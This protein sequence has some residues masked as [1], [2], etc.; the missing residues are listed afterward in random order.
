MN[1]E[2]FVAALI[3]FITIII[4]WMILNREKMYGE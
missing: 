1:Q 4:G 2:L 3:I